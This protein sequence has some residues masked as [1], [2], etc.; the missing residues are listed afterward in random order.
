MKCVTCRTSGLEKSFVAQEMMFGT[1]E[2]FFYLQCMNCHSIQIKEIPPPEVLAKYYPRDY[3]SYAIGIDRGGW[4][5]SLREILTNYRNRYCLGLGSWIGWSLSKY[6]PGP[7][8]LAVL[9][10]AGIQADYDVLDVGCG[11]AAT[12]LNVLAVCG[13]VN[14]LGVDPFIIDD[15]ST[16]NGVR[17][18][19]CNIHEV[20]Q[21]FDL[22]MFNH[23]LE[24]IVDP[25]ATLRVARAKLKDQG[26]CLVRIPTTS[27]LAW[28][29]Y[30]ADWVQLDAPRHLFV[31]SRE[32]MSALALSCGFVVHQ[33]ID[34]SSE[35]Q[36]VGSELYQRGIPLNEQAH[37]QYF[38]SAQLDQFRA[39]AIDAN[40]RHLGDQTAF[41][42]K[43][44]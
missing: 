31:P 14:L 6:K 4:T 2:L 3:Y 37:Q 10:A 42:L 13:F 18:L 20:D 12:L 41:L 8:I 27:S 35:F 40:A 7:A 24:H 30:G 38:T 29:I 16:K 33:V 32:G 1:R 21:K 15:I 26:I 39:R 44:A 43:P 22:I 9:R 11:S 28:K 36:F 19:K 17:V 23:S 34:D 5:S 25:H